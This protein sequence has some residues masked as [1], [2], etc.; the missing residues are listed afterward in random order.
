MRFYMVAMLTMALMMGGCLAP[1]CPDVDD[2][3]CGSDG[4][5]YRNACLAQEAGVESVVPG[6]CETTGCS[7]S[8]G[9][10]EIF[11]IGQVVDSS[12]TYDDDC[13]DAFK[14]DEMFCEGGEA[15]V[16][17]I[18]CPTGYECQAGACVESR[19]ADSDGGADE[20]EKGTASA[21]SDSETDSCIDKNTVKEYYCT[22]GK[23]V[24]RDITCELGMECS[25][26]ACVES[27]CEDSDGGKDTSVAGTVSK[28]KISQEDSCLDTS[29]VKEY[30][31]HNDQ[32]ANEGIACALGYECIGGK[33]VESKCVDSDMGKDQYT[34]GT[35]SYGEY[36]QTDS[37]YSSTS[38]IEYFC[39]SDTSVGYE[40]INC[41]TGHECVDGRCQQVECE[42]GTTAVNEAGV[43]YE[44]KEYDDADPLTL[45]A[46]ETVEVNDRLMLKLYSVVG[47]NAVFRLYLNYEDFKD[48]DLE[49][50]VTMAETDVENDLCGED[51]RSVELT[52]VNDADDYVELVLDEY[53]AMEYYTLH[54]TIDDWTDDPSCPE[55]REVYPSQ[56]VEFFP[57]ADTSSSGLDLD[58]ENFKLFGVGAELTDVDTDTVSF[59]IDGEDYDDL[60]DGDSFEYLG[61][62]YEIQLTFDDGG[63]VKMEIDLE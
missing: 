25:D 58:N 30:F 41:G 2:P 49:C 47:T 37:C 59:T 13:A 10:K 51:T 16:K 39:S 15:M 42:K 62:D 38:V 18:P 7:D 12:G 20:N 53:Y 23:I 63:L 40:K 6:P 11:T 34:K 22:S 33:C 36:S 28:G 45:Y 44:I 52:L 43:S 60:E 4:V 3:V 55:D 27:A 19:C 5:T 17:A 48:N 14:V 56:V 1:G 9:G 35:T 24:S 57:Y 54:G 46:G 21:G 29:T 61:E 8:D 32:I 31:C 26:G 50:S